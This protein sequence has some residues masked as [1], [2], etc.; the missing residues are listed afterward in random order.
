MCLVSEW[1]SEWV[2]VVINLYFDL[3]VS[4]CFNAKWASFQPYHGENKSYF[5]EKMMS[6]L[7]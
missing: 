4:D 3:W 5:D 6:A 2:S 7:H 1:V